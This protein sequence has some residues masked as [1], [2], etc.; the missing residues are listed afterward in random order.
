MS[1]LVT[2]YNRLQNSPRENEAEYLRLANVI[3]GNTEEAI[4]ITDSEASIISIN[5]AFSLASGYSQ[6]E[7]FGK[8]PRMF[9]SGRHDD[10]FYRVMWSSV[11][12]YGSWAGEI[13]DRHK[14]GFIY[15]KWMKIIALKD[16]QDKVTNYVAISTDL[17]TRKEAER[18]I[19]HL[20]YYDVLT[21]LPNRTLLHDRIKQQIAAAHRDNQQFALLFVDLDRFKYVNDSMGHAVGDRLLQAVALR[22]KKSV[23]EG[24][25]VSR[26]GGDEFVV[27]LRETNTEGAARVAQ[28]LMNNL[29]P[30]YE[31]D[32][33][34]LP[35]HASIGI[36]LYPDNGMDIDTLI[37][38]ADVAMYRAKEEGR[39]SF[40]FFTMEMDSHINRLFSM[41][42]D[43]RF[44]LER[45]EFFLCFQ[46]QMDIASG[47]LCGA[48][49][50]LRWNHPER[51]LVS[52]AEF[53]PIAEET[54]QIIPIGE[55]VLRTTCHK[56]ATWR[57]LGK[58]SVPIA[59]NLSIRQLLQP[60]FA[61]LISAII[62]EYS[63]QPGE[64]ELEVTE[65]IMLNSAQIALDFLSRMRELG[66]RL[67]I[68]DFG[69]GYSSLS[70]LKK[71]PIHKLKIDR[72]FVS[73]IQTDQNDMAIVRSIIALG[74]QFNLS[75]IAEG[76]EEQEQLDFLRTLDCD[77]IQGFLYSHPLLE[78]EFVKFVNGNRCL[79]CTE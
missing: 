63:L 43:L 71:L 19:E 78:D 34:Y 77:E 4:V 22:L 13:W 69:T 7:V 18:N 15:P 27:L 12:T 72:S 17:S 9:S 29:Q 68:D 67:S 49:A 44:A 59:V 10:D 46:P 33:M 55:W 31:I 14:E 32:G 24:D 1:P 56:I 36:S 53:I 62:Q 38:H 54:G 23:R 8:N 57:Q 47:N 35:A 48:E 51:G 65:S 5:P 64:L 74:H 42:K 40:R 52:P 11:N 20:A 21:D 60:H 70:Y 79:P 50:L 61:E 41:E 39:N 6:D 58:R 16:K 28:S 3:Y 26:V 73:N 37:K 76:I 66:I 2:L 45:N 30:L 75:V 25:T